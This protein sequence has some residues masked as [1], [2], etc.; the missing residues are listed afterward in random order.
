MEI[1]IK[2]GEELTK[3]LNSLSKEI[4]L[5]HIHYRLLCDLVKAKSTYEREFQSFN[6]FWTLTL[7]ALRTS[8][9]TNL[10]RVYDQ[11]STSLNLVNLLH[12][13]QANLHL[14]SE[15]HFRK[16]LAGNAFVDSLAKIKRIP[17]KSEVE[18]D[19]KLVTCK[20]PLVKKLMIWRNNI[21][22]HQ[23]AKIV[24][25]NNQ[26]LLNNPLSD[27]EIKLLLKQSLST[28]NKY[29]DLYEASTHSSGI[30]GHDDYEHLLKTIR[31]GF[32]KRDEEIEKQYEAVGVRIRKEKSAD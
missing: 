1:K 17:Q 15:V 27:D 3:L 31:F 28:F 30:I 32:Q 24:L 22:A 25:G 23:G 21:V 10:C 19:V 4:V 9:Q 26:V 8:Y 14:F 2:T 13:I 11:E 18:N 29:S 12:T 6:T 20:N 5:A 16:R 7:G